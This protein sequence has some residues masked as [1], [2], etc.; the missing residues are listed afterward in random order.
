MQVSYGRIQGIRDCKNYTF[1]R[2]LRLGK[3]HVF[4]RFDKNKN[5][6]DNCACGGGVGM[7]TRHHSLFKGLS[8]KWKIVF[9]VREPIAGF[10][11]CV[12]TAD[13]KFT[14]KD[15]HPWIEVGE[16]RPCILEK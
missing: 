15:G 12:Y 3:L 10:V 11:R 16:F 2:D 7:C 9:H 5:E 14:T 4:K 8:G 1:S 13:A 6:A